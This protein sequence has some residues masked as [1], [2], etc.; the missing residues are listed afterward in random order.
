MPYTHLTSQER[1]CIAHMHAHKMSL[2]TI[3]NRLSRSPSTISR[4]LKRNKPPYAVYWYES[5]EKYS[6]QRKSEPRTQKRKGHTALY[7]LVVKNIRQGLSPELI[8]GRLK[9]EYRSEKMRVSHEA[10][11]QWIF[12]D[13]KQ[14]GDLYLSLVR[15]HKNRRKQRRS[16]KRRLFE[17]RVSISERP[18]IVDDKTR[19]GDWESDTMEGGKSKGDLATHSERKRRY[20]VAGKVVDNRSDTF[21][22]TSI[23][24]F[25]RLKPEFIKTFTVDN[26]SEFSKFKDLEN[27]T[28]SKVYFADPYAPWQRGLNENTNGLLRRF[29]PKG[30]NFHKISDKVIQQAVEKLNHQPR[31]CLNFRTPYEVLFKTKTVALGT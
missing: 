24:C 14:G 19:F 26:G 28:A 20:L 30:C 8:S 25:K 3:S 4:E 21:M 29:F 23:K 13:A 18:K 7:N 31:K 22:K 10:I 9:R 12:A 2:R 15:H 6:K 1:Y 17:G 11:Y 16:C 27:A 5:A